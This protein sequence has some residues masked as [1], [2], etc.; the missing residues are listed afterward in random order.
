M[1][2]ELRLLTMYYDASNALD[3]SSVTMVMTGVAKDE[4][5]VRQRVQ[6]IGFLG[7]LFPKVRFIVFGINKPPRPR[8]V[9]QRASDVR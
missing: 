1:L 5:G 2:L 6:T 8:R 4:A 3:A 9:S 7:R